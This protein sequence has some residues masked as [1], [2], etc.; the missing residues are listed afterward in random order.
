MKAAAD[1]LARPARP[2]PDAK[3]QVLAGAIQ[4][5]EAAD[6][7][8]YCLA[9]ETSTAVQERLGRALAAHQ[10]AALGYRQMLALWGL[11]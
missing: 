11:S 5:Q 2:W 6:R 4:H 9:G 1:L 10:A 7:L 3:V 8:A